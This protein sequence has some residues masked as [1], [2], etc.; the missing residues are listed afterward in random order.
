M[1]G[2]WILYWGY[3][4]TAL[5]AINVCGGGNTCKCHVNSNRR[6][7]NLPISKCFSWTN[8]TLNQRKISS[9]YIFFLFF[10]FFCDQ[11]FGLS[12]YTSI[13]Y[14]LWSCDTVRQFSPCW[15]STTALLK[16][17]SLFINLNSRISM[18]W[19]D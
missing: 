14:G 17:F 6:E 15:D 11:I 19:L 9:S 10:F 12:F 3:S 8:A 7:E 16:F 1:W 2:K 4:R 5:A 18:L 13:F